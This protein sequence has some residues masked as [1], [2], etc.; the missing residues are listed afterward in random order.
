MRR[1]P[2]LALLTAPLLIVMA[3]VWSVALNA[4]AEQPAPSPSATATATASATGTAEV[5]PDASPAAASPEGS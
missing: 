3:L 1:R 4:Q 2:I 5:A